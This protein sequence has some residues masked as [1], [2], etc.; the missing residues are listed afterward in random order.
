MGLLFGLHKHACKTN[1]HRN[2]LILRLP[3]LVATGRSKTIQ[4]QTNGQP[5]KP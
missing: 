4:H 3:A 5:L 1:L 2:R